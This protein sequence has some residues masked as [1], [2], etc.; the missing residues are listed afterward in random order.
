MESYVINGQTVTRE[1]VV[2]EGNSLILRKGRGTLLSA[3]LMLFALL[4]ME[5]RT[6]KIY[7]Q[8]ELQYYKKLLDD[9]GVDYS[10]GIVSE[11]SV[12]DLR[13]VLKKE[14]SG[15]FYSSI[16]ELFSMDP[17]E[18]K[19]L[20]NSWAIMMP[21]PNSGILGYAEIIIA[22]HLVN[23]RIFIK[24]N[25]EKRIKDQIFKDKEKCT[26]L[27]FL[28][29]EQQCKSIYSFRLFEILW[30]QVSKTDSV[31]RAN[32]DDSSPAEYSFRFTIGELQLM[33]GVL[34]LTIDKGD[35]KRLAKTKNP[36]YNQIAKLC[37][38]TQ[39]EN[40]FDYRAFRRYSLD[41]A[42]NE[43]NSTPTSAFTIEYDVERDSGS[44][45]IV[46]I[47][48]H[49]KKRAS[50][51]EPIKNNNKNVNTN[52]FIVEIAEELKSF[53]LT[54]EELKQIANMAQYDME[55]VVAAHTIYKKLNIKEHFT[56][57]FMDFS[58]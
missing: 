17:Y 39:S 45:K 16:K 2:A 34:D 42:V 40:M 41:V 43:I 7:S 26:D 14:K 49:V 44:T 6:N 30:Y 28:Y 58:K 21:D 4:N 32:G 31:L 3:K 9:T 35:G 52:D 11:I 20:R 24:F 12:S 48:F 8:R 19:S 10:K 33:F 46:A 15:S 29:M 18:G 25:E 38:E 23:G 55:L 22:T 53:S 57:W 56:Q 13:R 54:Y 5:Y 51:V 27:P 1:T 50:Y 37:N 47:I 36:D